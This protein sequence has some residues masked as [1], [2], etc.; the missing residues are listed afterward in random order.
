MEAWVF[1]RWVR[2]L[3]LWNANISYK[4][5][6]LSVLIRQLRIYKVLFTKYQRQGKKQ[7]ADTPTDMTDGPTDQ[8]TDTRII[9]KLPFQQMLR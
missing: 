5:F 1:W 4:E 7:R 2:S 8:Q 3:Q 6:L 9:G